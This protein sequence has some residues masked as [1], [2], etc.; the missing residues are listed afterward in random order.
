MAQIEIEGVDNG[1]TVRIDHAYFFSFRYD[2]KE[3]LVETSSGCEGSHWDEQMMR[4][5]RRHA[6]AALQ[7][8]GHMKMRV[9]PG[10]TTLH[11]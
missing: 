8:A 7:A 9:T 3:L 5:M 6:L 11:Q 2:E 10:L 4:A 1:F